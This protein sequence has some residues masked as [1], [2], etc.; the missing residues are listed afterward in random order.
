VVAL[1]STVVIGATIT[2]CVITDLPD[3]VGDHQRAQI[4]VS[5]LRDAWARVASVYPD[6][7]PPPVPFMHTVT[8]H[9]RPAILVACLS[10]NGIHSIWLDNGQR[11]NPDVRAADY[12]R[13]SFACS[14]RY[15]AESQVISYLTASQKGTLFRYRRDFV[16]S[17]LLSIGL[18]SPDPPPGAKPTD[19]TGL[20]SWNPYRYVWQRRLAPGRPLSFLEQRCPPTPAWLDL[21]D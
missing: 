20:P 19:G 9:D 12:A 6:A 16:R 4:R 14:A 1:L 10:R 11:Y 7:D 21:A 3:P 5:I 15:P 17:C 2:G 8:D 13:L 18:P